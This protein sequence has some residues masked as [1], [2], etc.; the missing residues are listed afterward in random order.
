[1]T[2]DVGVSVAEG[3]LTPGDPS[4]AG[5]FHIRLP[6]LL[7]LSNER[8]YSEGVYLLENSVE[9][10]MWIGRAVHPSLLT[11]LFRFSPFLN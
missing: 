4:V 1:M 2:T 9:M 3:M 7:N 8:L 11:A 5:P 6:A 10:M